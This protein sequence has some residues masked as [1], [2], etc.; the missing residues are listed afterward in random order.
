MTPNPSIERR[1]KGRFAPFGPPLMSNYKG[2]PI[3]M[4]HNKRHMR[5][6]ALLI[7]LLVL[8]ATN[9]I[10]SPWAAC[11]L[12]KYSR[13]AQAQE[14]WQRGLAQLIA[15]VAPRHAELSQL[16]LSDQ[17]RKIEGDK[18]AVEHLANHVPA[19]LRTHMT[20]NNWL[21]LSDEDQ[22]RIAS[23][24]SRYREL[25]RL[26]EV[27]RKRPPHPGGDELRQIMRSEIM[28]SPAYTELLQRFSQS[29]KDIERIQCE[30]RHNKPLQPT[31]FGGG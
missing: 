11:T 20:L 15:A 12:D 13:Y 10:A 31:A 18:L 2:F 3:V 21:S 5:K 14:A 28:K 22:S 16:F 29:V 30:E 26:E 6:P 19:K 17:L 27:V 7:F 24:S 25:Q 23:Q 1:A 8:S 4:S 9:A